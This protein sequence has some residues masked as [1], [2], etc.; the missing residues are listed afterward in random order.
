MVERIVVT[1][2]GTLGDLNPF[3]ALGRGLQARGREVVVVT[4]ETFREQVL[5][6]GLEFHPL[7]PHTIPAEFL[8]SSEDADH[9]TRMLIRDLLFPHIRRSYEDLM[10]AMDGAGLLVTHMLSFAGPI[11][12]ATLSVP[13]VSAVFQPLAF[14]SGFDPLVTLSPVTPTG[15]AE[16]DPITQRWMTGVGRQLAYAWAGPV[17]QLRSELGLPAG[18][19]P[20]YEDHHSPDLVLAMFSP[21]FATPQP[22]WPAQATV[23]GFPFD[24][25][26]SGGALPRPLLEYLD[27]G[28][29]PV[30]FTLGSHAPF[31]IG[32]FYAKSI[33]AAIRLGCRAV[34]VGEGAPAVLSHRYLSPAAAHDIVAFDYAPFAAL[35]P[36]AAV[37]VHHGGIGTIALTLRAGRPMLLVPTGFDQPDNSVRTAR[38]GCARVVARGHYTPVRA[39][40]EVWRL[41]TDPRFTV[42]ARSLQREIAAEDGVRAACDAVEAY[43]SSSPC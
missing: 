43:L 2:L 26:A 33:E 30:V 27:A 38:L 8:A 18:S 1:T 17:R 35:F 37:I 14:F 34:L 32:N 6:L 4:S 13:W 12:A 42:A 29:P 15:L 22:D 5:E 10:A 20:I 21:T 25:M 19:N 28:P 31:D 7:A 40:A 23:T 39:A 11:V 3:L 36:R 16:V 9:D 24:D 41:L